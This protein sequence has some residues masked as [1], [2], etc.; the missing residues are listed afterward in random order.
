MAWI[1]DVNG[2]TIKKFLSK[3]TIPY[4]DLK[5][6]TIDS[7]GI[8]FITREGEEIT[9]KGGVSVE[10]TALYEAIKKNNFSFR[11]E[12]V[13]KDYKT[14]YT[15]DEVD[16]KAVAIKDYVDGLVKEPVKT[17]YGDEYEIS[18]EIEEEGEYIIMYFSLLKEGRPVEFLAPF[19]DMVIAF[20]AE[21]DPALGYGKYGVTVEV[22]DEEAC[23]NT[24]QCALDY[25]YD[26][27]KGK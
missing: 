17:K 3:R 27:Y 11:D 4:G 20:L 5:S 14:I 6:V 9:Q 7:T 18:L 10:A 2:I 15:L 1:S 8:V 21:W 26:A 25:L 24:V 23:K 16:K 19:D 13:L 22:E 12:Q